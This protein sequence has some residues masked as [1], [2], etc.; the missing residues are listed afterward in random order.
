MTNIVECDPESVKIGQAVELVWHDT[1][2]GTA[3]DRFRPAT[4]D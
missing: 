4:R 3:L 2:E 1:G